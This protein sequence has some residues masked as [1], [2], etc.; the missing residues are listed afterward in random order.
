MTI[1]QSTDPRAP[2][3]PAAD[4]S[5]ARS[6]SGRRGGVGTDRINWPATAILIVCSLAVLV[7]L[8]VTV[9]MSLKTTAQAVEGQAFSL[10][11]PFSF[12]GFEQAWQLTNFPRG[13]AISTFI[14]AVSVFGEIVI[15]ALAAFAI[16]RNWDRRLFR[17]S[18]FYL[19]AA[20]FIPFPV[21]ALRS[22]EHT[23]ELQSRGHLVCR[24]LLE[25]KK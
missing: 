16:V 25:K 21:V 14:T 12:E 19:L 7:P 3:G 11:V 20:M 8:F 13:H 2:G 10:P 5:P 4:T 22:E 18:F 9:N 23:S 1:P 15:S 24:L 6:A 17:W